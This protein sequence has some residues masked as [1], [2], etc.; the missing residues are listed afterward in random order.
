MY[1]RYV[2][3]ADGSYQRNYVPQPP[4]P[5][6]NAPPSP[7]KPDPPPCHKPESVGNFLRQLL[8]RHFDTS[9]LIIVLLLLLL[10]GDSEEEKNTAMLTLALY[11]FM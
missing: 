6:K 8:P 3:Q 1:N 10:C 2:P 7:P 11:L 9:D 4:S 5:P